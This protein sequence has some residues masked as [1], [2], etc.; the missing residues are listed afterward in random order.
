MKHGPNASID[1]SLPVVILA[2]DEQ[3]DPSAALRYQKSLSN[4]K[5]VKA[6]DGRGVTR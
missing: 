4:M 2:G 5:E 1:E 3:G 6:R